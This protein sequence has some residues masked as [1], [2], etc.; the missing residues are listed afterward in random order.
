[1]SWVRFT[2]E[3]G[4]FCVFVWVSFRCSAFPY[5]QNMTHTYIGLSPVWPL[6]KVLAQNLELV[7]GCCAV[8]EHC[9][10][11]MGYLERPNFTIC[12]MWPVKYLYLVPYCPLIPLFSALLTIATPCLLWEEF[13]ALA[14]QKPLIIENFAILNKRNIS[15]RW[16]ITLETG[17]VLFF[18]DYC[19][20]GTIGAFSLSPSATLCGVDQGLS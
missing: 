7:H 18:C 6:T 3:A 16:I 2:A 19:M 1:M 14:H 11:G 9:S 4:P 15:M 17:Q 20:H 10:S 13:E 12:C 8:P 5:N